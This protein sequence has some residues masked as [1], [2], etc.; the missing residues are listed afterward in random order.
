MLVLPFSW[1]NKLNVPNVNT[2]WSGR[3]HW[4]WT[5]FGLPD[6]Y[7][8]SVYEEFFFLSYYGNWSFME[9]YNLPVAIR[10]WFV[11]RLVKQKEQELGRD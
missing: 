3:C 4:A 5:F 11:K 1:T 2:Q 8:E 6:D 10:K 9:A 7:L